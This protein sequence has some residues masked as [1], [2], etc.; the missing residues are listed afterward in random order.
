MN[1][2][3]DHPKAAVVEAGLPG[4]PGS[5]PPALLRAEP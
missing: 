3:V 4:G 1:L 5:P 2:G